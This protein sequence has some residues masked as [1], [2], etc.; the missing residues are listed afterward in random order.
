MFRIDG[1]GP[2][3][4]SLLNFMKVSGIEALP[5]TRLYEIWFEQKRNTKLALR[6]GQLAADAELTTAKYT[7]VFTN[8][9]R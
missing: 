6:A 7:H 3:R 1:G 5:M 4:G 9:I 8:R 2:S